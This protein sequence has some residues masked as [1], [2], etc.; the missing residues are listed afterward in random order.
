MFTSYHLQIDRDG[1][2]YIELSE[3]KDAL[4]KCGFKMA[5]YQVRDMIEM[6]DKQDGAIGKGRLSFDEFEEVCHII[7]TIPWTTWKE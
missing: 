1:S 5:S 3:L 2:G 4:D 7:V 6:V